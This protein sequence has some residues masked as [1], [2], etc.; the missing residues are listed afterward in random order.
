MNNEY[1]F[2]VNTQKY[3]G[4][5]SH[6]CTIVFRSNID[7]TILRR[8][9]HLASNE[10]LRKQFLPNFL[11]VVAFK[12]KEWTF[13]SSILSRYFCQLLLCKLLTSLN[14]EKF[15]QPTFNFCIVCA[16]FVSTKVAQKRSKN[17][18]CKLDMQGVLNFCQVSFQSQ[19]Q[20]V[21]SHISR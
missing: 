14:F 5:S 2:Q 19:T 11:G 16:F 10:H 18:F 1:P 4:T 9:F 12:K 13:H 20:K 21:E 6:T 3:V 17:Y 15:N 7:F 8:Q